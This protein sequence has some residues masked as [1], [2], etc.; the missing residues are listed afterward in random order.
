MI[1]LNCNQATFFDVDDTLIL[2]NPTVE[3]KLKYGVINYVD[4]AGIEVEFVPYFPHIEQLKKH[5]VR[6]HTIVVWSAG[7]SH[8]AALAVKLLKLEEY[9]SVAMAKPTW[10]YDDKNP[11]EF[12]GKPHFIKD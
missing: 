11:E 5:A 2:W 10:F 3:Q 1:K 6:G 4:L 7:G 9:V 8:W 12:M